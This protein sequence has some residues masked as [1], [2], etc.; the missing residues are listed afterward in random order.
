M[1]S[2]LFIRRPNLA[3]VISLV[4]VLAGLLALQ[5]I[6][7]AQFPPITP[8]TVQV[9]ASYP[10]ANAQ[11]VAETIAAP[12]EAQVN[13]VENMMYMNSTST[14]TGAYTLT[15]TFDIGT[16]PDIAT[17]NVQNRLSLATPSLPSEVTRQGVTVRQQSPN[18]LMAVNIFS[19]DARYDPIFISNYASINLRDAI[20]RVEGVGEA[21]V[22]GSLTY[23]MRIWMNPDRMTALGVTAPEVVSAI[24]QQNVQASA[25]QI[26]AP[27]APAGQQQQLTILAQGRLSDV[28]AFRNI[29]VRTNANGAVVRVGDIGTVELG[30]QTYGSR[31]KLNGQPAATLVVYQA[32]DANALNVAQSVEAELERLSQRFPEGLDYAV[33]FDTTRFV[34]ATIEEI[35][36]TLAITFALVVAVTYLFLQDWRSTLIPTLAIPVSLIGVFAVLLAAGYSANTVTLFALILA[37]GLVVDDAIVV[38]EN[39]RRVMEEEPELS[40]AE[41]ARRAMAQVT[42]PIVASTLVLAAV[43]VPVAFLPGI[44]G[45]LYRQFAV[46]ISVSFLIS[47]INSLT[48]SPALCALLLRRTEMYR[49]GPFAVFNRLLDRTRDAYGR[50]V[51]GGSRWLVVSIAL[52]LA[53][54]LGAGLLMRALPSAFL[55]AEDQGYFF[56]NVQLPSAAALERSD[57][58]LEDVQRMIR[59]TPGVDN[60]IAISGFSL[61]SGAGSNVG[62]V[63][64]TLKP[65]EERSDPAEQVDGLLARLQPQLAAI[66]QATIFAFNPP[67]I[68]GVGATGG[69]DFRLQALGG[70]SPQELA[71]TLRGLLVAANQNPMLRAV[72][73][74]YSA[75]VPHLFLELDRTKAA[76]LGITPGDVFTTLQAHLGSLYVN[77]FNL[78]GRVFRVMVQDQARFRDEA[79]AI[80]RLHVRASSGELVPLRSIATIRNVLS[81]DAIGRYNQFTAASV[82]GQPAP[83]ASSGDALAAMT[84]VANDT[85]PAGYGFEW[86]GVSLQEVQTGNQTVIVFGLAIL[87][88]Y[89]FLVAQFESWMVP[90]SV[91]LSVAV[92]A[93]GAAAGLWLTGIPV[94]IYAQIGF[95][96]LIGLAAKNAI[97]IVEFARTR[98][99]HGLP[100]IEAAVEGARTRFRAVL[101]TAIAFILGVVPLLVATGAGAASRRSIGT[102]VF[103]GMMAATIVGIVFVPILFTLFERVS[104]GLTRRGG[105]RASVPAE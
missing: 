29:I 54:G 95:V 36:L 78:Y 90:L 91:V 32:A 27:P 52:F 4:I 83:G 67:S 89:L 104:E 81:P 35:V 5:V 7:V 66:P 97:L 3:I 30:A 34:N 8:P 41:A 20:A 85:L 33:V 15:V 53:I 99:E 16:D 61:L 101:M 9:T 46:T 94:D 88:A 69:F 71:S 84:Q 6:P 28:D 24:Q 26:G 49:R 18:M 40:S 21:Q 74:T 70:Q 57:A 38:V 64:A 10:G 2:A 22:M 76:L 42:G 100:I 102:T 87:F 98:R 96:L 11:V 43:F 59:E 14:D 56:V 19:P 60:V 12:I 25:G 75:E 68:P 79:N 50:L 103:S 51:A 105:R 45:Q 82:N 17:V 44:T 55:P 37:I 73:S 39:V 86:S 92:A 47:G 48:L 93:A 13:G 1:I 77:D 63:I 58:V 62:L 65:W 72:F 23:S 31:S 80:D